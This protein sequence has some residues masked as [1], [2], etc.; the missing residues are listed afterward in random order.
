MTLNDIL[1]RDVLNNAPH[2]GF[3]SLLRS[4]K[5]S[6][7]FKHLH[8]YT[9]ALVILTLMRSRDQNWAEHRPYMR[10]LGVYSL[11]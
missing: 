9:L 3:Q 10:Y 1:S 5:P 7:Y 8:T 2:R 11:G 4:L 6:Y